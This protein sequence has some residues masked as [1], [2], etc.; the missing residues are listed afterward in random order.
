M[1]QHVSTALRTLCRFRIR[2]RLNLL[3]M[4][5]ELNE[6]WHRM[7]ALNAGLEE[8][9]RSKSSLQASVESAELLLI[10]QVWAWGWDQCGEIVL[11]RT[12]KS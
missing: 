9:V 2:H 6:R 12:N 4:H 10:K 3:R 1:F 5:D 11:T 8:A 7:D